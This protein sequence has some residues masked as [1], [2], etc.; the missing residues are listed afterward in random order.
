MGVANERRQST[1]C[2]RTMSIV[3]LSTFVVKRAREGS[4]LCGLE[5]D[6]VIGGQ[7]GPDLPCQ[8]QE[9]E[10]P[11]DDLPDYAYGLVP[12]HFCLE[13]LS[14]SGVMV[15]VSGNQGDIQAPGFRTGFPLSMVQD[16]EEPGPFLNS[17][18][19]GMR[20]PLLGMSRELTPWYLGFP[21]SL[22]GTI[23]VGFRSPGLSRTPWIRIGPRL[24]TWPATRWGGGGRRSTGR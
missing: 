19:Q 18:G 10:V 5:D 7:G 12:G 23:H 8:H 14:P 9:G 1:R 24:S 22:H 21:G 3:K 20:M 16:R 11:G 13:E 2:L 17:P 6:R 15:E 4:T